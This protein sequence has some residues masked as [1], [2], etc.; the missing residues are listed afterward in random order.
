[1]QTIEWLIAG[2]A[3]VNVAT[4]NMNTPLMVASA[5]GHLECANKLIEAGAQ[6]NKC[7]IFGWKA[8]HFAVHGGYADI[9]IGTCL[10][11]YLADTHTRTHAHTHTHARTHTRTHAHTH[12]R[13][14]H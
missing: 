11:A 13:T 12:T 4:E 2:G 1:M 8:L 3:D 9:V 5:F 7:N 14:H 6:V 10:P